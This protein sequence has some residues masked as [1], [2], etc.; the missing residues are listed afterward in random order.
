MNSIHPLPLPV[1]RRSDDAAALEKLWQLDVLIR[2]VLAYKLG[3]KYWCS[4][5]DCGILHPIEANY[6]PLCFATA[7]LIS[8][9]A[10]E[11]MNE[12]VAASEPGLIA[13]MVD[14]ITKGE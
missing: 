5:C 10:S 1:K 7:P 12:I 3:S 14:Y 11:M 9:I 13:S 6:C 4:P 8:I 2:S